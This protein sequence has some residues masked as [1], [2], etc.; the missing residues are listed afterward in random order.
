MPQLN[1]KNYWTNLGDPTIKHDLQEIFTRILTGKI[2]G[3][4]ESLRKKYRFAIE[5][6]E[7]NRHFL[8]LDVDH[9]IILNAELDHGEIYG[10][11][12]EYL[13]TYVQFIE[14]VKSNVFALTG[15]VGIDYL[16]SQC[17][18]IQ[19]IEKKSIELP[20]IFGD[21]NQ[22][23]ASLILALLERVAGADIQNTDTTKD[24]TTIIVDK[25]A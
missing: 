4:D 21:H 11:K 19:C 9:A 13:A 22:K 2:V 12:E 20:Y 6:D 14:K 23:N 18:K 5:A 17:P 1:E 10:S 25:I 3:W 24:I 15:E 8:Y 16:K 7:F